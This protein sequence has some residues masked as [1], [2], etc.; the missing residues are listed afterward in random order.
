[1]FTIS[2][3]HTARESDDT[4]FCW[5][6]N[7]PLAEGVAPMICKGDSYLGSIL[8]TMLFRLGSDAGAA[9]EDL[10]SRLKVE[11]AG[12]AVW[13]DISAVRLTD[14]GLYSLKVPSFTN[15]TGYLINILFVVVR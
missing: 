6:L 2:A 5:Q 12:L 4:R 7:G 14:A 13:L 3:T 10:I 15:S 8:S 1:M 11:V 9:Y